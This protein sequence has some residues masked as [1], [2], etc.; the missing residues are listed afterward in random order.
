M[1][2]KTLGASAASFAG[3]AVLLCGSLVALEL[4]VQLE[5]AMIG[6]ALLLVAAAGAFLGIVVTATKASRD[7]TER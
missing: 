3:L 1:N 6:A 2:T 4:P 5:I 7:A